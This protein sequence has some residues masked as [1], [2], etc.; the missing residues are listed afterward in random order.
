MP[1]PFDY[2]QLVSNDHEKAREF[3]GALFDW[4]IEENAAQSV[5]KQPEGPW[6]GIMPSANKKV[7]SMWHVYVQVVDIDASLNLVLQLGGKII[8]PKTA[9]PNAGFIAFIQDPTGAVLGLTQRNQ[10]ALQAASSGSVESAAAEPAAA[11]A[12]AES[13]QATG[14]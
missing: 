14:T 1:N 9:A 8:V 13:D 2:M 11:A 12:T 6:G 7:P 5:I 4:K 10:A 3:Y